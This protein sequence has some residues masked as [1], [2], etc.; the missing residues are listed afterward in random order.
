MTVDDNRQPPD[1]WSPN[2][3]QPKPMCTDPSE[4]LLATVAGFPVESVSP[5]PYPFDGGDDDDDGGDDNDNDDDGNDGDGDD[6]QDDGDQDD[7]SSND[8]SDGDDDS[9][10]DDNS[11]TMSREQLEA[12]NKKMLGRGRRRAHKDAAKK[13]AAEYG[14]T[15][16]EAKAALAA[17]GKTDSGK[18]APKSSNDDDGALAAERKALEEAK[19]ELAAERAAMQTNQVKQQAI[20]ALTA[21]GARTPKRAVRQLD[22]DELSHDADEEDFADIVDELKEDMPEL[23]T[24]KQANGKG[25]SGV[26]GTGRKSPRN[27]APQLSAA[28]R[29]RERAKANAKARQGALSPT[30]RIGIK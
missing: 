24:S 6:G 13:F 10:D 15:L 30:Q 11:V 26:T 8:S 28:E 1:R 20:A 2:R 19:A 21:A 23:F 18:P 27:P 7:S 25:R 9:D 14:M 12:H 22:L 5:G 3:S 17:V 16:D 29:G 4:L